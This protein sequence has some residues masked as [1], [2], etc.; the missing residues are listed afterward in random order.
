MAT[1]SSL[2]E[3]PQRRLFSNAQYA[4]KLLSDIEAI[5]T[6]SESKSIFPKFRPDVSPLQVTL[7]RNYVA[8]FRDHLGRVIRSARPP[9]TPI[10]WSSGSPAKPR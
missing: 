7:I 1:E 3:A 6:A 8:R 4:D 9:L 2:N 5:L 10:A